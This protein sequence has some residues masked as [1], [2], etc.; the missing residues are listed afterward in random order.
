MNNN[1]HKKIFVG[2]L[3]AALTLLPSCTWFDSSK[4]STNEEMVTSSSA[5]RGIENDQPMTGDVVASM[6]GKPFITS[7]V[8]DVEK[9][10]IFKSNPQIKAAI[11]FMD[12]KVL[13][14]NLTD[15]LVSQAIVDKYIAEKGLDQSA[16]Y[17]A[18]FAD[19]CK[20]IKRMLNAK[21]FTQQ[22]NV[23]VTDQEAREF[24]EANKNAIPG[25]LISHG[26]VV[27]SGI[28]F[29]NEANAKAFVAKMKESNNNFART[30]QQEN[31]A[32]AIKDFK[33][34]NNQSV[35]IDP[36]LRDKIVAIKSV[37]TT[38]IIT[39]NGAVWVINATAKEAPKYHPFD[40]V[41]ENLKQELEKG[42]RGEQF[43]IE[44]NKL[45]EKYNVT[46][47]EDYFKGESA[48]ENQEMAL[49]SNAAALP[50][51]SM[52]EERVA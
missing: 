13:D 35:G 1:A 22:F 27:A 39:V 29:D 37:P 14:R 38:E 47:N 18:E 3:I 51:N 31:V 49:N 11:A 5:K 9:E 46:I 15:G 20:A 43:E 24:Y 44:I 12:P 21:F 32:N 17:K 6:D 41:K 50:Q 30:A 7:S 45:K 19:A 33:M 52:A 28:Q 48:E 8:L 34:V 25:L 23:M 10:N 2:G 36:L 4:N 26:G 42:K 40:Q 16:D